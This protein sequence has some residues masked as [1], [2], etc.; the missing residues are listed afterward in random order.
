MASV[1]A[2]SRDSCHRSVDSHGQ[3][4]HSAV[5]AS[6]GRHPLLSGAD[7]AREYHFRGEV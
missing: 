1:V 3:P 5:D 2:V 7:H 4:A 6:R